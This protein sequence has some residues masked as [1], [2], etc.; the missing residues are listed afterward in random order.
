MAAGSSSASMELGVEELLSPDIYKAATAELIATL[1]FVFIGV[2][3]ILAFAAS[4]FALDEASAFL[5]IAF[6]HGLAFGILVASI[7]RI[8]GGHIN[9]AITFAALITGRITPVRAGLY[10][11][12]QVLGAILGAVLIQLFIDSTLADLV[13][14]GV[15]SINDG[16]IPNVAAA[17]GLEAMLTFILVWVVF[18][19]AG[20]PRGNQ[21]IAPIAIGFAVLVISIVGVPLTGTGANPARAFGP[22]L[23]QNSWSDHW[24]YWIGPLIGASAA[25]LSYFFLFLYQF[26]RPAPK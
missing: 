3:S 13:N 12:A 9:P 16:V 5:G 17:V 1:L 26:G 19:T 18:A 24:V 21:V 11:L 2:G 20:D 15:P 10:L 22:A 23:I 8:S 6:A 25:G 4:L 14:L 7:G